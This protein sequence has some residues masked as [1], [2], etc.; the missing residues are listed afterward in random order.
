MESINTDTINFEK[1]ILE[2]IK[3]ERIDLSNELEISSEFLISLNEEDK[4]TIKLSATVSV[5][6]IGEKF[7]TVTC[8]GLFKSEAEVNGVESIKNDE[9]SAYLVNRVL[10]YVSKKIASIML[11]SYGKEL[12][13]PDMITKEDFQ[14][15]E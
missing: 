13:I 8:V 6:N 1:S 15:G 3:F 10:P 14:K 12:R 4:K 5:S 7:L 9:V 11:D 2:S